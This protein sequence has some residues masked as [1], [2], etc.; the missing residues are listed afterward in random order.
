MA[1][2]QPVFT[3]DQIFSFLLQRCQAGHAASTLFSAITEAPSSAAKRR[4]HRKMVE[5][6]QPRLSHEGVG[7]RPDV[8]GAG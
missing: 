5:N 7:R 4:F 3:S 6:G 1:A 8:I 2:L